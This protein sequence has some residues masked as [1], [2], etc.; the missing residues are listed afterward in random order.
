MESRLS[1]ILGEL[2]SL[3]VAWLSA[4][5]SVLLFEKSIKFKTNSNSDF[6][7]VF[8]KSSTSPSCL[9]YYGNKFYKIVISPIF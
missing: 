2:K 7:S 6:S 1:L 9:C 4:L 5:K 8:L 3:R